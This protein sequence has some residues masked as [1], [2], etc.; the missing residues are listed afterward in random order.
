MNNQAITL[1]DGR[2]LGYL[3]VGRGKPVVY[4]H[5][6]ASSR[7]EALLLRELAE[8]AG[9]KII[10]V[11]RAG[12]GLS[13]FQPRKNLQDFNA[14]I[15]HLTQLLGIDRFG[16]LGWS[17]GGVFALAY[18]AAYPQRVTKAVIAG[19]PALPFDVS[20]AHNMPLAR[21]AMKIPFLGYLAVKRMSQ[22]VLKAD[23]DINAFLKSRQGKQMLGACSK[24]DLKFFTNPTWMTLMHQAMA[25]AFRQGDMGVK[26]VVAE[27]EVFVK[28]W[29]CSFSGVPG[30]KLLVLHGSEDKT[31]RASNA[32]LIWRSV[33]GSELDIVAGQGHC[34]LFENFE[35]LGKLF[36]AS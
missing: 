20:A 15:N 5:G 21:F 14:D 18:L 1:P 4:F 29:S 27:H 17:G 13:T 19:T 26:A 30:G 24:S 34:V 36:A 12:Y 32:E 9:L 35:R 8:N 2:Q 33:K 25:E 22:Q 16:V 23:G 10:G 6:T 31:C 28:P 7:L 3:I 11:D